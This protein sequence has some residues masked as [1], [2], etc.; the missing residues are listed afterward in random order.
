MPDWFAEAVDR[1]SRPTLP[2][3]DPDA[4]LAG[5][6]STPG[7]RTGGRSSAGRE[8]TPRSRSTGDTASSDSADA[9]HPLSDVWGE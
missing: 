1:L 8:S 4:A 9:D 5:T 2:E 7:T 3:F 6:A